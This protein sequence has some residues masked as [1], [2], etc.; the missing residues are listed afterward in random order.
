M[1]LSNKRLSLNI[2]TKYRDALYGLAI[3]WIVF[4]H[5][6]AID[7]VDYSFG[8]HILRHFRTIMNNGSVGVDIFLFLSGISLYF[9][10]RK[11]PTLDQYIKSRM[12]RV[13]L[14]LL[15][16]DG[17][18]WL[19][20]CFFIQKRP[21]LF[22]TNITTLGLW[23]TGD[24]MIWF[25]S[26][27]VLLYFLYPYFYGFIYKSPNDMREVI[28]RGIVLMVLTYVIITSFSFSNNK[29]YENWAIAITRIPVFIF[30][31][32]MG[33]FV[34][35]D[36]KIPGFFG[37]LSVVLTLI[38]FAVL[39]INLLH[40]IIRRYWFFAGGIS[41]AYALA[42][43][44]SGIDRLC[45]KR[46]SLIIRFFNWMGGFSL[47]LYLS[48]IMLNRLYR[49]TSFYREGN[50]YRYTAMAVIAIISAWLA[51]KLVDVIK[52]KIDDKDREKEVA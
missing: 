11:G 47:E 18:Y 50:L 14:P 52:R 26:L 24:R 19:V 12:S 51:S 13:F 10:F 33:K 40:D 42:L 7:N 8:V 23:E 39:H 5:A 27:I 28:I 37:L 20:R 34:Y 1:S 4:F 43:V 49:A 9:S 38:F 45:G 3:L 44:F 35:D 36:K 17:G 16:I 46:D 41:G 25:V 2:V 48:H 15:I 21:E 30:G 31:C 22:F 29:L 32:M 6:N